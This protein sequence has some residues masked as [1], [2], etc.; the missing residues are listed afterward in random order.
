MKN[1]SKSRKCP[2]RYH[3]LIYQDIGMMLYTLRL[4]IILASELPLEEY[5]YIISRRDEF[6]GFG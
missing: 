2:R 3:G 1:F 6:D 4:G 5:S